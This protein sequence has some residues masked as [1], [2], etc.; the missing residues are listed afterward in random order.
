[1]GAG[2]LEDREQKGI[3]ANR[4]TY[5]MLLYLRHSLH[6]NQ[7]WLTSHFALALSTASSAEIGTGLA[8]LLC[9]APTEEHNFFGFIISSAFSVDGERSFGEKV[10]NTPMITFGQQSILR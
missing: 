8:N 2:F 10:W 3:S 7:V 6:F 1:M 9:S 4:P 5:Q